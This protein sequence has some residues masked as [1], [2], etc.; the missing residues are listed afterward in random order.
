MKFTTKILRTGIIFSSGYVTT[1]SI[2][3]FENKG[4]M[5]DYYDMLISKGE[6]IDYMDIDDLIICIDSREKFNRKDF[7][8]IGEEE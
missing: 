2:L 5:F 1:K 3:T 4:D 8:D 7:E 6:N